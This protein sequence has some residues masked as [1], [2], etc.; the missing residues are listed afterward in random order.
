[1]RHLLFIFLFLSSATPLLADDNLVL[2]LLL[3][4]RSLILDDTT[5]VNKIY[6]ELEPRIVKSNHWQ[7]KFYYYKSRAD[8]YFGYDEFV[9]QA[10]TDYKTA[11][12]A[13][14]DD[15]FPTQEY[16]E[17]NYELCCL[18]DKTQQYAEGEKIASHA[19][20]R[21]MAQA[22]SCY[23]ASSLFSLLANFY[24]Q[25]GDTIMPS[26]FHQKAQELGIK[27]SIMTEMPDSIEIYN[28]RLS[29]KQQLLANSFRLL[30]KTD[31]SYLANLSDYLVWVSNSGNIFETIYAGERILK[32]VQQYDQ[33]K[34][35][36]YY[37]TYFYLLYNY[38]VQGNLE[39]LEELYPKAKAY[40]ELFPNESITESLLSLNIANGLM[41]NYHYQ[42]AM[43]YL[44]RSKSSIRKNRD[45]DLIP[46]INEMMNEC[47]RAL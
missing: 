24:E 29:Q 44:K 43:T 14:P 18:L 21:G 16:M 38:A 15:A 41:E 37:S 22:D 7:D 47:K 4:E 11:L 39:K 13:F 45:E 34:S 9:N 36:C 19:L 25:R 3:I 26:H 6:K 17:T 32:L 35:N 10:I 12:S 27:Y 30:S 2:D 42:A 5:T 31:N 20:V 33:T 40:Y 8:Y 1:M 28:E 23:A 46:Q